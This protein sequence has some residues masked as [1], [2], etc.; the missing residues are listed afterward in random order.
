MTENDAYIDE[1]CDVLDLCTCP[2]GCSIDDEC[3]VCDVIIED[4]E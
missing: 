2:H 1:I 4:E 3:S